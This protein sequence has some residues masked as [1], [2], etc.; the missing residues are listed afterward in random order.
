MKNETFE[1]GINKLNSILDDIEKSDKS[2]DESIKLYEDAT[3]LYKNLMKKLNEYK[4]RIEIIN[5][6]NNELI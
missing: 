1:E 2:L 3:N 6:D 5:E 4:S